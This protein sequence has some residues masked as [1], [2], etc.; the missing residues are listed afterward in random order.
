MASGRVAGT[1][2]RGVRWGDGGVGVGPLS[3]CGNL[4]GVVEHD[5][6]SL[7]RGPIDQNI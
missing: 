5:C 4:R 7:A 3:S 6:M 1:R 2:A